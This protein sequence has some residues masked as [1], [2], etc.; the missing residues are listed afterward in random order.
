[1]NENFA[2]LQK[3]IATRRTI[4][5]QQMNG[6]KIPDE[7]ISNVIDLANFAPSHG[8]TEPWRFVVYS[9]KNVADF[10]HSH[11]LMYKMNVSSEKFDQ[12]KYDKL[13]HMGDL[14][15]HIIVCVMQ[16][17]W[18]P[19]IAVWEEEAAVAC[20][21]QNILLGAT[22]LGIA[23]YWGSGGMTRHKALKDFL[24]INE[25]DEVMGILYLGYSD[26]KLSYNRATT[27]SEKTHW[28]P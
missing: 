14:A 24:K 11:A 22:T 19:K 9:E 28:N 12:G 16:R 27:A 2:A 3:I 7:Q 13:L 21:I 20:A 4:K 26:K 1:M 15:S 25:P 10:C 8:L 18:L 5:P 6:Q 17:G 23:T